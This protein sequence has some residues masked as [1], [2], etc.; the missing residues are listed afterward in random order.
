MIG[1]GMVY[2]FFVNLRAD[3]EALLRMVRRTDDQRN[4]PFGRSRS[5]EVGMIGGAEHSRLTEVSSTS[6]FGT[7]RNVCAARRFASDES[8]ATPMADR[9]SNRCD[10]L[11]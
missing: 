6:R 7:D 9:F 8:R 11:T 5:T 1:L 10:V 2:W 3:L 4:E